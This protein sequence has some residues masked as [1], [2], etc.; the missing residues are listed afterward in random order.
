[1]FRNSWPIFGKFAAL[2]RIFNVRQHGF[3]CGI[4]EPGR[5]LRWLNIDSNG[6]MTDPTS[7]HGIAL[8][9][10]AFLS[11]QTQVGLQFDFVVFRQQNI[12]SV[13][14]SRYLQHKQGEKVDNPTRQWGGIA[15]GIGLISRYLVLRQRS[16]IY[17]RA[18][19]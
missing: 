6:V 17:C 4:F 12:E 11:M 8:R 16:C 3:L 19:A 1:M 14:I 10:V 9:K 5:E 15:T 18:T 7:G 13:L 2:I